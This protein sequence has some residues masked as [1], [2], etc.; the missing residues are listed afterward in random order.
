MNK[1][2]RIGGD[3]AAVAGTLLCLVTGLARLFGVYELGGVESIALF[4]V[5]VGGMVFACLVKLHL[6]AARTTGG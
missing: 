6:L 4:T 5:G 2:I 3:V 1:L